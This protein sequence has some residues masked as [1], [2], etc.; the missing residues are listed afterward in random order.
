MLQN[1]SW[2]FAMVVGMVLL[3]A[4]PCPVSSVEIHPSSDGHW[5]EYFTLPRTGI[6]P[7]YTYLMSSIDDLLLVSLFGDDDVAIV[8]TTTDELTWWPGFGL[9]CTEFIRNGDTIQVGGD[10]RASGKLDESM[11][12]WEWD[13][14]TWRAIPPIPADHTFYPFYGMTSDDQGRVWAMICLSY[15]EVLVDD[16]W[17]VLS[18]GSDRMVYGANPRS[19]F[20]AFIPTGEVWLAA[21]SLIISGDPVGI[22]TWSTDDLTL[23]RNI[24]YATGGGRAT[25]SP[26]LIYTDHREITWI[27][28]RHGPSDNRGSWL[29]LHYQGLWFDIDVSWA[30]TITGICHDANG[31]M[32][33]GTHYG[34]LKLV[35][36]DLSWHFF[37]L[38]PE[39]PAYE[40]VPWID[41]L[42]AAENGKIYFKTE[43]SLWSFE[44]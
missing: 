5:T 31:D 27:L 12:F 14:E 26:A 9:E 1:A 43:L 44:E 42:F 28:G 17:L 7:V 21:W 34:L 19:G 37:W 20:P 2:S 29:S 11:S 13:S 16:T 10:A 38:P 39:I 40:P 25:D 3:L 32:W 33:F 6:H 30:P 23:T 22:D 18:D 41:N 8:N 24:T 15:L 4:L 36:D 35:A